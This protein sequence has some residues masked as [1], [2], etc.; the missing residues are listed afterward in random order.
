MTNPIEKGFH[1]YELVNDITGGANSDCVGTVPPV[2]RHLHF[3]SAGK[4]HAQHL[5]F[6]RWCDTEEEAANEIERRC[7]LWPLEI[8]FVI[9]PAFRRG[10]A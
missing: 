10:G 7:S 2:G 3:G 5:E 8:H 9:L 6:C 4:E 1:L